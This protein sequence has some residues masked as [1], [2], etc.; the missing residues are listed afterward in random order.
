MWREPKSE[1]TCMVRVVTMYYASVSGTPTPNKTDL[2]VAEAGDS[3]GR[4]RMA[5]R[6][7]AEGW[8]WH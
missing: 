3:R 6:S 7:S 8:G 4:N 2:S 5:L 1:D